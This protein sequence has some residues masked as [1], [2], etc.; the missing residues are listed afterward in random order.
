[1]IAGRSALKYAFFFEIR[2]RSADTPLIAPR[3]SY[4]TKPP[5]LPLPQLSGLCAPPL[6]PLQPDAPSWTF[7]STSI[8]PHSACVGRSFRD[9]LC[10]TDQCLLQNQRF[11]C[12]RTN[13]CNTCSG[14]AGEISTGTTFQDA[15]TRASCGLFGEQE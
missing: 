2:L 9:S 1:M 15:Q 13:S 6:S 5:P 3:A 8:A 4:D 10:S 7:G 12:P 14:S 11:C